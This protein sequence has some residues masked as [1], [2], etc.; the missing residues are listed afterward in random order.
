MAIA[1]SISKDTVHKLRLRL[2]ECE[3]HYRRITGADFLSAMVHAT[4]PREL[5]SVGVAHPEELYARR[6]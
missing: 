6:Y 2:K 3:L 4:P 5:G 1:S